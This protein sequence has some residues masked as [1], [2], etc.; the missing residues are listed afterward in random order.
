MSEHKLTAEKD[1]KGT[2][3][4]TT[5]ISSTATEQLPS[6]S[7][8]P[9]PL[10]TQH[11]FA[12]GSSTSLSNSPVPNLPLTPSKLLTIY[13]E[14]DS[15]SH[16]TWKPRQLEIPIFLGTDIGSQPLYVSKRASRRKGNA[17]LSHAQRGDVLATDYRFGFGASREP[18]IRYLDDEGD[19]KGRSEK[20]SRSSSEE[21]REEGTNLAVKVKSGWG[22]AVTLT[23]TSDPN[24]T[25]K[26]KYIKTAPAADTRKFKLGQTQLRVLALFAHGSSVPSS[27]GEDGKFLAVLV[28]SEG[29]RTPG[30]K[31]WDSGNGGQLLLGA[32]ATAYLNE[33]VIVASC[34][35]M[36][37]KE[38]DRNAQVVY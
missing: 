24:Q 15:W 26:W 29:T 13:S 33:A 18:K 8:A 36:L 35:M 30:T 14:G 7:S 2:L 21:E 34:V 10:Y 19:V 23:S 27:T 20:Q 37:K 25:F 3:V 12:L 31:I 1:P 11:S 5:T 6:Y 32:E 22:N 9:P 17:V 16:C 4:R 38:I 28:R